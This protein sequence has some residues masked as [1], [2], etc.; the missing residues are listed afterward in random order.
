MDKLKIIWI[1][2][3]MYLL[4]KT[5]IG[6]Y[7]LMLID[8]FE[9]LKVNYK[10]V[11]LKLSE[12]VGKKPLLVLI[13][14]NTIL[15]LKTFFIRP[16]IIIFP[17]CLMPFM[18]I[19]GVK[20][21]TVIHDLCSFNDYMNKGIAILHRYGIKTAAKKADII[22]TVSD[23]TKQ[24]L[25][26]LLN[27]NPNKIKVI[28]NTV[29]KHFINSKDNL[30]LL[31]KY[32]IESH[33][34]ILSVATLNIHKNIPELIK[35]FEQISDK[36]PNIKLVLV[37]GMGNEQREKLT[38]HTNI[39]FTGYVKD[40][41]LPTLYKNALLYVYPSLYEGFGIPLIEAQY[42]GCPVLCSDIPV[43]KEI[44]ANSVMYCKPT[45]EGITRGLQDLINNIGRLQE[46]SQ[47]GK[48]NVERFTIEKITNQVEVILNE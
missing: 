12:K 23:S 16:N 5:G 43:F 15:F 11:E 33:K 48:K 35:A 45:A 14:H 34:Y 10:C 3:S 26:K 29:P 17:C 39:I 24:D 4:K 30:S 21:V 28:Y 22:V 7:I 2:T 13:W 44:G 37:G 25:I 41:E 31:T 1:D 32:N 42:S 36:Y 40:D 19:R 46:L 6:M 20:Y 27:I 9:R 38:K 8:C 18:Q 47:L